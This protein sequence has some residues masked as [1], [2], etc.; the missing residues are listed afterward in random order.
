MT[1]LHSFINIFNQLWKAGETAHINLNTYAGKAWINIRTPLGHY[2]QYPP[3]HYNQYPPKYP[4][5]PP[6]TPTNHKPQPHSNTTHSPSYFCRQQRRKVARATNVT[7]TNTFKTSAEQVEHTI[8]HNNTLTE[9]VNSQHQ[10]IK[11]SA[12]QVESSTTHNTTSTEEVD[13]NTNEAEKTELA[14]YPTTPTTATYAE[15]HKHTIDPTPPNTAIPTISTKPNT[16]I[17]TTPL[18]ITP[19]PKSTPLHYTINPTT[20][21]TATVTPLHHTSDPATPTIEIHTTSTKPIITNPTTH[22]TTTNTRRLKQ[23]LKAN[24]FNLNNKV[25]KKGNKSFNHY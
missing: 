15:K 4:A 17:S 7:E 16:M 19:I 10:N 8:T 25:G 12:E 6:Q 11:T 2:N 5:Y 13:T 14:I 3:Y 24:L 23:Q 1:K 18:T 20:P 9:K 22:A 21:T